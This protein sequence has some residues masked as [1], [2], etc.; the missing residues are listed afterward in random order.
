MLEI[1]RLRGVTEIGPLWKA[2]FSVAIGV[3]AVIRRGRLTPKGKRRSEARPGSTD[4]N[5][6]NGHEALRSPGPEQTGTGEKP[7]AERT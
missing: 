5:Q 2:S 4:R 3:N 6:G 1:D 7:R